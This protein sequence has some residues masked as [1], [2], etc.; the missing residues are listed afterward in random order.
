MVPAPLFGMLFATVCS[1]LSIL[2]LADG[3]ATIIARPFASAAAPPT[4]P[5]VSAGPGEAIEAALASTS[6][7]V[8]DVTEFVAPETTRWMSAREATARYA[9]E[10]GHAIDAVLAFFD[11]RHTGLSAS[12]L[13]RAAR[14]IVDEARAQSLEVEL[15]LA[16][17][18]IESG[19]YNFAISHVGA[20]GLMQI[21][22]KTGEWLAKREGVEWRGTETLFDPEVNVRLGI[23]YLEELSVRYE[24]D[25]RTALAAYNW[26]PGRI[27]GFLRRGRIV[28]AGYSSKVMDAYATE[29]GKQQPR[30]S[31]L[32]LN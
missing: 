28:P 20:M 14:A 15:V 9:I 21:M 22:P 7:G 25:M 1:G 13:D 10:D 2:L 12:E 16:V 32:V 5:A 26:G 11:G 30:Q 29:L 4:L 18:R 24:G 8:A 6:G 19:G 23:R 3:D 27:D 17:I 31:A